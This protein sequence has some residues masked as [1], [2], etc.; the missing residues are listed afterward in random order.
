MKRMTVMLVVLVMVSYI[1]NGATTELVKGNKKDLIKGVNFQVPQEF[2]RKSKKPGRMLLIKSLKEYK[3]FTSLPAPV[4]FST[5]NFLIVYLMQ[6]PRIISYK[7]N[8]NKVT[9]FT[10]ADPLDG[11]SAECERYADINT[12]QVD[13]NISIS[14]PVLEE[15]AKASKT[16]TEDSPYEVLLNVRFG[17]RQGS[18]PGI[19]QCFS[20]RKK[21][22]AALSSGKFPEKEVAALKKTDIDFNKEGVFIYSYTH[23]GSG[24]NNPTFLMS[25]DDNI[26]KC[27]IYDANTSQK[28]TQDLAF[29]HRYI[30]IKYDKSIKQIDCIDRM[31]I[32]PKKKTF[33]TSA[34]RK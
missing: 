5:H 26:I 25:H 6:G 9:F 30:V 32:D 12:Y 18:N 11:S 19:S 29:H 4:D 27:E 31:R 8:D 28:R 22:E 3:E 16:K 20:T 7:L 13:K 23:R 34:K 10:V 24:D 17:K 14:I 21:F 1:A 15:I 2:Y 33:L